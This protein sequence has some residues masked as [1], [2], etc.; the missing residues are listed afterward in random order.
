M[1]KKAILFGDSIRQIGYGTILPEL[2]KDDY[3]IWQSE[4]NDRFAQY[5]LRQLYNC[6]EEIDSA[7]VIHFNAGLWDVCDIFG[8]GTFT[9][10]ETYK[11]FILRLADLFLKKGKTVIFATTTPVRYD[12]QHNRNEDIIRFNEAV[13]PALKEKGVIIND[14]HSTVAS[15]VEKYIREDDKIHLTQ[16]GIE[17]V[18]KQTADI[19]KGLC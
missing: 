18:A 14:L 16:E 13:V 5:L 10:I 3:D 17:I 7:D 4:D 2:V 19:L 15:D 12:H 1:K 8:D 6:A 11:Y 9:P